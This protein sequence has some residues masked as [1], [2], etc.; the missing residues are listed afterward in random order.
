MKFIYTSVV[1]ALLVT[2][3]LSA[4]TFYNHTIPSGWENTDGNYSLPGS[5]PFNTPNQSRW[6]WTYG[7]E[8][9]THQFPILITEIA[10][11]RSSDATTA[12]ATYQGVQIILASSTNA[13]HTSVSPTFANNLGAD[14]VTVF[15]GDVQI[16]AYT[17][18][19]VSPAPFNVRVPLQVPFAFDPSAGL[20]LVIDVSTLGPTP[21]AGGGFPL[22]GVFPNGFLSQN[23]HI[24]DP[25]SPSR[26]WFNENAGPIIELTYVFGSAAHFNVIATTTG[27]GTGDLF[28]QFANVPATTTRAYSLICGTPVSL[29]G[30]E[31]GTGPVFG[32]WFDPLVAFVISQPAAAGNPFHW[33]WP[34]SSPTFPAAPLILPPGSL[35]GVAGQTWEVAGVGVDASGE[36]TGVTPVTQLVW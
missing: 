34:V 29:F 32:V 31:L 14:M 27:G 30:L 21:A 28:F 17:A 3:S 22:D 11:R 36:V 25:T 5:T 10:F 1:L 8:T 26:N 15:N 16:P 7:R 9:L 4:Q 20:D 35:V 2:T 23:G 19:G 12:A 13:S 6:Q 18:A 24:T 33:T